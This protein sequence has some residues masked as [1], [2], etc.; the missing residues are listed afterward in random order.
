[1]MDEKPL[2]EVLL[3][4]ARTGNLLQAVYANSSAALEERDDLVRE[5]AALHNEG[6]VDVVAAFEGLKN[7]AS[8]GPDFFLT[9]HVFE[10]TLPHLSAPVEPVMRCVLGLCREAGQDMAAGTIFNG[11]I[12][13]CTKDATRPREALKLIEADVDALVDML[14]AT[15]AAGSQLDNPYYLAELLRLIQHPDIEVRRRAVF[16]VARIFWP[17]GASVPNTAI[18]ALEETVGAEMDDR[19]LGSAIKS[20]FALFEQDKM[21][22]ERIVALIGVAL[23]KGDEQTLH[24]ASELMW[25]STKELPPPLLQ[26]LLTHLKRV[27]PGNVGTLN[28]IDYGIAHLLKRDDPEE[29]LRFLE[30]L[31]TA[32]GGGIKLE[33]LDSA[34]SAIRESATLMGKVLTRWLLCGE[35]ALCEAAHEIAGKSYGND[36]CIEIDASELKP[37]DHVHIIF[38]ARKAIGYFFMQPVTAASIVISLM[39]LAPDDETL[40]ALGDLLFDPLLLNYPGGT[41]DYVEEQAGRE[42]G[43]VKETIENAVASVDQYLEVLRAIPELPALHSGQSQRESYRRHMSESMA[44]SMKAAEKKSI[45]ASLFSRSTL[46]Y[47]NKSIN[48]LYAGD[49]EPRRMEIPLNKHGVSIEFPRMDNI[50]PYGLDYTL[51]IFR[52][53]RFRA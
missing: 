22:E 19:T 14:V 7:S 48:Y 36:I 15:I 42:S 28:N 4:G 38:I 43:K 27:K 52:A 24:A 21:L 23:A 18:T 39:R 29:G 53:E 34:A 12:E 6:L 3:A 17:K 31:L 41:R 1:M 33:I 37:A 51:R 35:R 16:A 45:F 10:K 8:I 25:L 2:R 47:G 50:D 11:Y 49:G 20:A 13:F 9:R 5:L 30:E 40:D 46:L 44:E 26:L 32:H